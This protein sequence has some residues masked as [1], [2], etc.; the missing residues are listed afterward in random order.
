MDKAK[1]ENKVW[2]GLVLEKREKN[3]SNGTRKENEHFRMGVGG[4]QRKRGFF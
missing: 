4:G 3:T 1:R 2:E